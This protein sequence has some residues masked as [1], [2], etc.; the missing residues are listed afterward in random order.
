MAGGITWLCLCSM[1]YPSAW[2]AYQLEKDYPKITLDDP[3]LGNYQHA[4]IMACYYFEE[5]ELPYLSRWPDCALQRNLQG[6][7]LA[8]HQ[9]VTLH[10]AG[11]I[12]GEM[13]QSI[14]E[15]N[16]GFL[17]KFGVAESKIQIIPYGHDSQSE[18]AAL[19][20]QLQGQPVILIT[21]ASHM[22]RAIGYFAAQDIKVLPMP[23]EHLS[24]PEPEFQLDV[25]NGLSLARTERALHE[26]LGLIY[27]HFVL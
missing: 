15:H 17:R 27:Q 18:I 16:A 19:A 1:S 2:L 5:E 23:I 3:R 7:L 26:Y 8:R 11:G 9:P 10:L 20:N 22:R 6:V 21:S 12:L 13:Q 14:A 4:V 24:S 25:P